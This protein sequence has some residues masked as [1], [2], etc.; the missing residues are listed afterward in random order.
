MRKIISIFRIQSKLQKKY[1]RLIELSVLIPTLIVVGCL[2]YL[3][4]SLLAEEIAIPEFIALVLAPVVGRI[5]AILLIGLPIVFIL[6]FGWGAVLSHRLAGPID[7]LGRELARVVQGDYKIR[8]SV[9]KEDEVIEIV[10]NINKI[11]DKLEEK[12]N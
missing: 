8:L 2:Y 4:F 9:R 7:R 1:L 6:L 3:V 5:N 10:S 12:K 11:L